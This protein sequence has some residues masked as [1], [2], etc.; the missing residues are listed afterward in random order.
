M[1]LSRQEQGYKMFFEYTVDKI[2]WHD[3]CTI[4]GRHIIDYSC[5]MFGGY[6]SVTLDIIIDD[7]I[8][9]KEF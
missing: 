6:Y 2:N 4:Y 9:K 5:D 1:K 7:D 8:A 3:F